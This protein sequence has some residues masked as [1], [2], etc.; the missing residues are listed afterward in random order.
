MKVLFLNASPKQRFSVS[1][2]FL[3]L[4][5]IQMA[6]IKIKE[7]KLSGKKV[8]EEIFESFKKIDTLVIALPVYVDGIPSNILEFLTEAEYFCKKEKCCFKVYIVSN[9]GFYEGQ[10]C[11]NSLAILRSFCSAAGLEWGAGL[12]IG[13]G[14][15][16]NIVRLTIPIFLI[17]KLILSMPVLILSGNFFEGLANYNWI[18][19]IINITLFIAFNFGLFV[20]L[21]KMQRLIVKKKTKHDFYIKVTCCPRFLFTYFGNYY[22]IIRALFRGTNYF[23]LYKK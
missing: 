12:G 8:Y 17:I 2:Y 5:K 16:F 11:K 22:W 20:S 18:S 1:Q 19:V 4:L 3:D 15:M 9:C 7:V 23:Q 6:G 21:F 10:Q 13:S 14:E